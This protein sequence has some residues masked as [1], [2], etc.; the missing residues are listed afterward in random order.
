MLTAGRL[1]QDVNRTRDGLREH[2]EPYGPS[3][4]LQMRSVAEGNR[5]WI[6]DSLHRC[7]YGR[8]IPKQYDQN[9]AASINPISR[10]ET[11]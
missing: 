1:S 8:H 11:R 2:A 6:S 7:V 10:I 4:T 9:S 3:R 5:L